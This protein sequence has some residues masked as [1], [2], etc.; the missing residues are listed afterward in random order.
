MY[1][2]RPVI[3]AFLA[4]FLATHGMSADEPKKEPALKKFVNS[5]SGFKGDRLENYVDFS[6]EYPSTWEVE[7]T[8]KESNFIKVQRALKSDDGPVTQENFAVGYFSSTG[9]EEKGKKLFEVVLASTKAQ[10]KA[11]FPKFKVTSEG[12]CKL[13]EATG[14]EIRF[15]SE[16]DVEKLGK[17][18]LYMWMLFLKNPNGGNKGAAVMCMGTNKAPEL[19]SEKD[20]G[21]KGD[22]P[23]ILK[24]FKFGK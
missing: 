19:K 5:K 8:S 16:V 2:T 22:L 18:E 11:S 23:A 4:F 17:V 20:L 7:D 14:Y 13:G 3:A 24:S 6:F 10:L 15:T 1:P 21:I 12:E 9:D